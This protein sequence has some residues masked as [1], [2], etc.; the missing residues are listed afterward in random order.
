MNSVFLFLFLILIGIE[1][2]DETNRAGGPKNKQVVRYNFFVL[3]LLKNIFSYRRMNKT[4]KGRK[5]YIQRKECKKRMEEQKEKKE[6]VEKIKIKN[7]QARK[8]RRDV[9]EILFEI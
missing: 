7:K 3:E 5:R 1:C 6:D 9:F 8:K 2:Q 4:E